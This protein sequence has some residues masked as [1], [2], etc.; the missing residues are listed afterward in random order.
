MKIPLKYPFTFEEWLAHPST[1]PK[2]AW[3]KKIA[4][5]MKQY[6]FDL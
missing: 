5:E 1:K 6:K 3:C 2:L 4:N